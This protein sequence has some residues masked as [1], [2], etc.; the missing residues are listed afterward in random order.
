MKLLRT[1]TSDGVELQGILTE[2]E[3]KEQN[4]VLHIHGT[5]GNFYGNHFIDYFSRQYPT[6]GY[7]FLSANTRGHD[8]GA[9]SEKFEDCLLDIGQWINYALENGY[10]K[11]VLQGHSLGALK[12]VYFMNKQKN[13]PIDKLI[14]LSPFDP[15]AFYCKGN[16]QA[17]E[18][19]LSYVKKVMKVSPSELVSKEVWDK[20]LISAGTLFDILRKDSVY[21]IFPFRKGNLIESS[22]TKVEKP[23]FAAIGG[24][25]FAAFPSPRS[26]Y[27]Q[28]SKLISVNSVL[29]P[30]APHNFAGFEDHLLRYIFEWIKV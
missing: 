28:L 7:S 1:N 13:S 11:I 17:R 25:D 19:I 14:L 23:I 27:E 24:N 20:W 12:A 3:L 26:E 8:D 4:L 21:D 18:S 15:I 16:L 2:R 10:K 30:D 5:W 9:I 29:I 22:L 6:H